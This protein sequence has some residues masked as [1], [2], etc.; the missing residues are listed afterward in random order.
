MAMHRRMPI[1]ATTKSGSEFARGCHVRVAVQDVTDLIR[2]FL[3]DAGQ[4]ELCESL[5]GGRVKCGGRG[6]SSESN[7]WQQN[8]SGGKNSHRPQRNRNYLEWRLQSLGSARVPRVGFDVSSEQAFLTIKNRRAIEHAR[9]KSAIARR[10]RQHAR[11]LCSPE[12]AHSHSF[13]FQPNG[14]RFVVGFLQPHLNLFARGG[15]QIFPDV[16]GSNRQLAMAAID[17]YCELYAR[18]AS[19]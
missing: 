4:G 2:V 11:R 3:V 5:R 1:I 14:V 10:N 18:G 17:Q 12:I 9:E 6:F 7:R 19:E 13:L 8:Q 16:I 15:R